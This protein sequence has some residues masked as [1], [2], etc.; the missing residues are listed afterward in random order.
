MRGRGSGS[1]DLPPARHAARLPAMNIIRR[2]IASVLGSRRRH[3]ELRRVYDICNGCGRCLPL[4]PSFK[5]MFDRLDVDAVD[6]DV[7]KLPAS[8]VKDVVDLCHQCHTHD[9]FEYLARRQADG[10]LDT[11]FVRAPGPGDV[12]RA[13]APAWS[14]DSRPATPTRSWAS[15]R[16]CTSSASRYRR[17]RGGLPGRRPG[18]ARGGHPNERARAVLSAEMVAALAADLE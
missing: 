6:G 4:C 5:V 3:R 1:P 11:R 10:A 18:H 8:D 17:T 14:G 7:E 12:S 13:V 9:L 15:S 2:H 16:R